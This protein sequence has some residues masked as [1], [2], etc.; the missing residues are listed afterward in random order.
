MT[1]S[2]RRPAWTA[3]LLAVA[4]VLG[5]WL[6][7]AVA[8]AQEAGAPAPVTVTLTAEGITPEFIEVP[9]G[10]SVVFVNDDNQPHQITATVEE[11]RSTPWSFDSG[12]LAPR[13][14][15][16]RA[17]SQT[18]RFE[19]A[20]RYT[21]TDS[22]G[23]LL[24]TATRT[25]DELNVLPPPPPPSQPAPGEP[26]AGSGDPSAAPSGGPSGEPAPGPADTASPGAAPGAAPGAPPGAPAPTGGTGT[27][28]PLP[29]G[30]G[31]GSFGSTPQPIPG[32]D[33][34]APAIAPPL[35]LAAPPTA[36][37][38]DVAAPSPP[39]E[40]RAPGVAALP[41]GSLPGAVTDRAYGLPA[42]LAAVILLGVVSLLVR[43]LLAE[44]L[45]GRGPAGGVVLRPVTITA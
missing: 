22:R 30:G 2:L 35:D 25:A 15:E 28:T 34:L 38:P 44:P 45:P 27:T 40:T 3:L 18:P 17:S 29:L 19:A 8:T 12:P 33:P 21:F 24:L 32:L 4:V 20:G 37:L 11:G 41:T 31:F 13:D 6:A 42:V 9:V 5:A 1:P 16:Q 39:S 26:A 43:V 23:P 14:G 10:G 7:P 36:L